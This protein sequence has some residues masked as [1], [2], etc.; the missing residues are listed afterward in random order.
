MTGGSRHRPRLVTFNSDNSLLNIQSSAFDD[1]EDM[2][3]QVQYLPADHYTT[4]R[5]GEPPPMSHVPQQ[6]T[7]DNDSIASQIMKVGIGLEFDPDAFVSKHLSHTTYQWKA[8]T[9]LRYIQQH[10]NPIQLGITQDAK[11]LVNNKFVEGAD[12]KLILQSLLDKKCNRL[13]TVTR[14]EMFVLHALLDAPKDIVNLLNPKKR[15]LFEPRGLDSRKVLKNVS[16]PPDYASDRLPLTTHSFP[17]HRS[18]N[19]VTT[20][21][22]RQHW[23]VKKKVDNANVSQREVRSVRLPKSLSNTRGPLS[24][25]LLRPEVETKPAASFPWYTLK[26]A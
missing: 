16:S 7:K 9:V 8:L 4:I 5:S 3:R 12:L 19:P 15:F 14:G 6:E 21:Q 11:L 22:T 24:K 17:K 18:Q 10:I 20:Q 1:H 25:H 26:N 23:L 13:S 2:S